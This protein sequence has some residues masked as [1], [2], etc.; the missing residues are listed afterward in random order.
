MLLLVQSRAGGLQSTWQPFS[1]LSRHISCLFAF[2]EAFCD[3]FG[4]PGSL[5]PV[6]L[7]RM[8]ELIA[9]SRFVTYV[10]TL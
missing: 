3:P 6:Y 1:Q 4:F 5:K 7:G 10:L 2:R 9:F 8:G